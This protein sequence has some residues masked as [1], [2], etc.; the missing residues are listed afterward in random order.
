MSEVESSLAGTTRETTLHSSPNIKLLDGMKFAH[1]SDN[2]VRGGIIVVEDITRDMF[3]QLAEA[4]ENV[5][6]LSFSNGKVILN[7]YT[8]SNINDELI[9]F[10]IPNSWNR[11]H[12]DR[13][14]KFTTDQLRDFAQDTKAPDV[15]LTI[16]D[17]L[18]SHQRSPNVVGEIGYHSRLDDLWNYV[19]I[20][21]ENEEDNH[22]LAYFIVQVT[23]PYSILHPTEFQMLFVLFMRDSNNQ[24]PISQPVRVV[25]CGTLPVS[26]D[27]ITLLAELSGLNVAANQGTVFTGHGFGGPPC[28]AA[29]AAHPVYTAQ[30][31]GEVVVAIDRFGT[32]PP[33]LNNHALYNYEVSLYE[34]Q[35]TAVVA[36]QD[37][38]D[39]GE[40][41]PAQAQ[42]AAQLHAAGGPQ[43]ALMVAQTRDLAARLNI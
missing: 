11:N 6:G 31:P 1:R 21:L 14:L 2:F 42:V 17:R 15:T 36:F 20:Y 7:E 16:A 4:N 41:Q 35:Q 12:V 3:Y 40:N 5:R 34:L 30:L 37:M 9:R 32:L 24:R 38:F 28:D 29:N 43:Q 19:Q 25:S 13:R 18:K 22:T 23:Y 33:G 8:Q 26:N 10:F 39:L 27:V